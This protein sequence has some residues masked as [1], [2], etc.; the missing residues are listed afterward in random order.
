LQLSPA[1]LF[2]TV[3]EGMVDERYQEIL[4]DAYDRWRLKHDYLYRHDY[5][6]EIIAL[7][8]EA[9]NALS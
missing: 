4:S 8:A 2:S 6:P 7:A 5:L 9:L 3:N 1:E